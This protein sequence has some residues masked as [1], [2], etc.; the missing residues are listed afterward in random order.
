MAVRALITWTCISLPTKLIE[1]YLLY[2]YR[3]KREVAEAEVTAATVAASVP[4]AEAMW[5]AT[6]PR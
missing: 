4:R 1:P 5:A 3:E 2:F 6:A